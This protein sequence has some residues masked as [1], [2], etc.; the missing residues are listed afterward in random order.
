MLICKLKSL[1]IGQPNLLLVQSALQGLW[2][3]FWPLSDGEWK[4]EIDEVTESHSIDDSNW[5]ALQSFPDREQSLGRWSQEVKEM[6]LGMKMSP[7]FIVW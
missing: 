2:E 6:L 4:I 5:D 3:G 7:I 1:L